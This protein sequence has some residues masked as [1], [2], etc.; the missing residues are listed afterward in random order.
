MQLI[1]R[2][3]GTEVEHTCGKT[4]SLG[5]TVLPCEQKGSLWVYVTNPS[6]E[7]LK[8]VDV[9]VGLVT[10]TTD[11]VGFVGFDPL[12]PG[13]VTVELTGL[14]SAPATDYELPE[15]GRFSAA[16]AKGQVSMVEFQLTSWIEVCL[17]DSKGTPLHGF[18]MTIKLPDGTTKTE[19]ITKDVHRIP[20]LGG[21]DCQISFAGLYDA[22]WTEK[23]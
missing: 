10:K 9:K 23:K 19:E 2:R 17:V 21:G 12:E 16:I 22:E 13:S 3:C 5:E 15:V 7:G 4:Q 6:G 18:T 11:K 14:S 8:G 1:C 20:N